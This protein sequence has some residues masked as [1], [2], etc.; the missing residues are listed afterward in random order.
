MVS[1]PITIY[2]NYEVNII[3]ILLNIF[4]IP[5]IGSL[6]LPLTILTFIFPTLDNILYLTC[7]KC[8]EEVTTFF[9]FGPEF[10]RPTTI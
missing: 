5:I 6:I 3:S 8:G 9:R 2:I 10:F 1:L 7:P 4:L